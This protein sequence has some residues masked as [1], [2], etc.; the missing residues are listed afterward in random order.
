MKKVKII[1]AIV[2]VAA[3]GYFVWRGMAKTDNVDKVSSSKPPGLGLIESEIDSLSRMPES[4]SF[5]KLKEFYDIIVY[6]IKDDFTNGTLGKTGFENEQNQKNL[7]SKLY[8]TYVDKFIKQ[9]LAVFCS[10]EWNPTDLSFIRQETGTL[11]NSDFLTASPVKDS[12]KQIQQTLSKY[13]EIVSFISSCRNPYSSDYRMADRFPIADVQDKIKKAQTYLANNPNKVNNCKHLR[14][15]LANVPN[16]LFSAHTKY[17]SEKISNWAGKYTNFTS[18]ADYSKNLYKP[19]KAEI[20]LLDNGIY[21]VSSFDLEYN[22]LIR[23][24]DDDN[25]NAYNYFSR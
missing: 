25:K 1:L 4:S 21:N 23:K 13:N 17:L 19:L 7:S 14:D 3:I 5:K 12:F 11:T 10:S 8:A 2:V 9:A 16:D 6:H 20:N 22:S 15:G 18:Q 24:L